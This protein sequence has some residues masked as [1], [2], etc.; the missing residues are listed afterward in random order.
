MKNKSEYSIFNNFADFVF[1]SGEVNHK[2]IEQKMR[3]FLQNGLIVTGE[4]SLV[5][6]YR[7][8]R[9]LEVEIWKTEQ[10]IFKKN[11]FTE[12]MVKNH[13]SFNRWVIN[14]INC[15]GDYTIFFLDQNRYEAESLFN[16][17]VNR[18]DVL[19]QENLILNERKNEKWKEA[20]ITGKEERFI[21]GTNFRESE[22]N[23]KLDKVGMFKNFLIQHRNTI[24]HHSSLIKVL[25]IKEGRP[26]DDTVFDYKPLLLASVLYYLLFLFNL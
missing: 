8:K 16:S 10:F 22:F 14:K 7:L 5:D 9:Y 13:A 23:L 3:E 19:E 6:N 1:N 26:I 12:N 15:L 11:I 21:R 18:L 2:K 20:Q 25:D 4:N 17:L 24:T